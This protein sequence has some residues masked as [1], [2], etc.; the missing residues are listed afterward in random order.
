MSNETRNSNESN[1]AVIKAVAVL[2]EYFHPEDPFEDLN[3]L[4]PDDDPLIDTSTPK[5]SSLKLLEQ[6][7]LFLE[8]KHLYNNQERVKIE[9]SF[10]EDY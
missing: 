2:L 8:N 3:I 4:C 9:K 7:L 10:N 5:S 1:A 6:Y